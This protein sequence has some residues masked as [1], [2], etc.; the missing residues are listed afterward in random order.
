MNYDKTETLPG[1]AVGTFTFLVGFGL[2]SVFMERPVKADDSRLYDEDNDYRGTINETDRGY[3]YYD[4]DSTFRGTFH[5]D[6]KGRLRFYD[7]NG[8]FRGTFEV[9]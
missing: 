3:R 8:N 2:C 9:E 5:K 7:E 4:E 1:R 6:E